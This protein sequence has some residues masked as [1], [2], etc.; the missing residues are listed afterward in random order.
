[1][2]L[3][4]TTGSWDVE[5]PSEWEVSTSD[6]PGFTGYRDD[7]AVRVTWVNPGESPSQWMDEVIRVN[8]ELGR[9]TGDVAYGPWSGHLIE[10]EEDGR[11]IRCWL[12]KAKS[13]QIEI[14]YS[15][16]SAKAG[17]DDPAIHQMLGSLTLGERPR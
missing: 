7:A 16:L 15:C 8:L 4:S 2:N 3:V 9:S 17:E 10:L 5:L 11:W 12:L 14:T 13:A 6:W 1:V